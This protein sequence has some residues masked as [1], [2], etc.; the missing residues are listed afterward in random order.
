MNNEDELPKKQK[1]SEISTIGVNI[2]IKNFA[3]LS[4][5]ERISYP[6][7]FKNSLQRVKVLQKRVSRKIKGSKREKRQNKSIINQIRK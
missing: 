7:Y 3:V 2:G 5:G 1:F 4:T 6:K